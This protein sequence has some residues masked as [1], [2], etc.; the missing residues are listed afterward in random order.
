M[1]PDERRSRSGRIAAAARNATRPPGRATTAA[2]YAHLHELTLTAAAA[3]FKVSVA[4]VS[5]SWARIYPGESA[6]VS[7]RHA[8]PEIHPEDEVTL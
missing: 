2:R 8:A 7:R 6:C 4:A 1:T 3:E 5:E